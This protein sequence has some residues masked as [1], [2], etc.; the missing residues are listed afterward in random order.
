MC[1]RS[2]L[3][4]IDDMTEVAAAVLVLDESDYQYGVGRLRIRVQHID[5]ANPVVYDGENWFRV[6]GM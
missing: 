2:V 6:T 4:D 1:R 3:A 5:Q